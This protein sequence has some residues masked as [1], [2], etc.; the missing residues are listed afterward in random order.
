M[1]IAAV[2]GALTKFCVAQP[3][4]PA[5]GIATS[6]PAGRFDVPRARRRCAATRPSSCVASACQSVLRP[7]SSVDVAMPARG[8]WRCCWTPTPRACRRARHRR[9]RGSGTARR[10][11]RC[12]PS[13]AACRPTPCSVSRGTPAAARRAATIASRRART[14]SSGCCG[15]GDTASAPGATRA[16]SG[17]SSTPSRPRWGGGHA[18]RPGRARTLAPRARAERAPLA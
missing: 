8:R 17:S 13:P 16:R 5:D 15:A 6:R 4:R 3:N 9:R 2:S 7:T 1:H 10:R 12:R 18:N 14:R 11:R